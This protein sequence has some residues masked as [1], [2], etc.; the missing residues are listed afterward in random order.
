MKENQVLNT[1]YTY[2]WIIYYVEGSFKARISAC[3]KKDSIENHYL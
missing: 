3:V 1:Q 2:N